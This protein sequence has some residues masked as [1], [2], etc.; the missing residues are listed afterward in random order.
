MNYWTMGRELDQQMFEFRHKGMNGTPEEREY[1]LK[2]I[3]HGARF[4]GRMA[5]AAAPLLGKTQREVFDALSGDD[6][7]DSPLNRPKR[8]D[9]MTARPSFMWRLI[10]RRTSRWLKNLEFNEIELAI[11]KESGDGR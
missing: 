7:Q 9:T 1:F 10:A 4:N 6:A 5:I 2:Q 3:F 11:I 8:R